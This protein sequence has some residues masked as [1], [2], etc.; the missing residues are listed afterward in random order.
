MV[1]D[2]TA[3]PFPHVACS[4]AFLPP[5]ALDLFIYSAGRMWVMI[6]RACPLALSSLAAL[7]TPH[8]VEHWWGAIQ[9]QHLRSQQQLSLNKTHAEAQSSAWQRYRRGYHQTRA[10]T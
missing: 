7:A 1:W 4:P 9:Q 6:H 8:S 2:A 5:S 3:P 10:A